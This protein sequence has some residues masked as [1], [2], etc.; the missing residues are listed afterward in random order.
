MVFQV[1][2]V[3][4]S[5]LT[6]VQATEG[7]AIGNQ[8]PHDTLLAVPVCTIAGYVDLSRQALE[9]GVMVESL[10][11]SDLSADYNAKLD[12]QVLN[13]TGANGQHQGMLGVSGR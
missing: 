8:D 1:P 7:G 13:G 10:V 9:R 11:F 5:T 4:T 2:R 6:A 12:A 3:T